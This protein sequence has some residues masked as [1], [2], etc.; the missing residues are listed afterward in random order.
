MTSAR[1][2][3]EFSGP[4]GAPILLLA[5][6]LGTTMAMWDPQLAALAARF[7]VPRVDPRGHGRSAVPPG[8]YT[9]DEIGGDLLAL[10]DALAI[11]SVSYCGLS[12]GGMAGMW[13]AAHAPDRIE[14]LALSCTSAWLRPK[15]GR[16]G[17]RTSGR[18]SEDHEH[19][20]AE[21]W[22]LTWANGRRA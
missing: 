19:A 14:R 10:L 4:P 7:R 12:L 20:I 8:P 3:Y 11:V 5:G 16:T 22:P 17:R 15:A 2:S 21:K 9:I 18:T 1:L 6:S 13:L